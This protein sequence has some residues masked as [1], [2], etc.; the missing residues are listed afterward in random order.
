[1]FHFQADESCWKNVE[2]STQ[3]TRRIEMMP[4]AINDDS[5]YGNKPGKD[6]ANSCG[7]RKNTLIL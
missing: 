7:L 2:E 5:L 1:M 6:A 4:I 3:K